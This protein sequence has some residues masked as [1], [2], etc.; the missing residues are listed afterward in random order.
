MDSHGVRVPLRFRWRQILL[1]E[2]PLALLLAYV[3]RDLG[4]KGRLVYAVLFLAVFVSDRWPQVTLTP[5]AAVV[6]K[7]RRRVIPW[8]SVLDITVDRRNGARSIV[9]LEADRVTR[10]RAPSTGLLWL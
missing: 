10:L 5:E 6:R 9:L 7:F 8:T 2:L 1:A 4:W 3:G